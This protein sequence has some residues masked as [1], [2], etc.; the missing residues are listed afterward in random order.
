MY[1]VYVTPTGRNS[2]Q[3]VLAKQ[4]YKWHVLW[5]KYLITVSRAHRGRTMTIVTNT[6]NV[7][8]VSENKMTEAALHHNARL[9]DFLASIMPPFLACSCPWKWK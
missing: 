4:R 6:K 9:I 7:A 3:L 8:N 2:S 1:I 5:S